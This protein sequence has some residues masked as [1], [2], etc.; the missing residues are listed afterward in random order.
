MKLLEPSPERVVGRQGLTG[1]WGFY[2]RDWSRGCDWETAVE[3]LGGYRSW[4]H[5]PE[6]ELLDLM[7]VSDA[8]DLAQEGTWGSLDNVREELIAF[9]D[10]YSPRDTLAGWI[11]LLT[12]RAA[13]CRALAVADP[14]MDAGHA[15]RRRPWK[16]NRPSVNGMSNCVSE[17]G[18][19][20]SGRGR[21]EA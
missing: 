16:V 10:R 5:V 14:E 11:R 20:T 1:P 2:A 8:L 9:L 15:A 6:D 19:S 3:M 18:S 12:A 17:I 4:A 7:M 21:K 13:A